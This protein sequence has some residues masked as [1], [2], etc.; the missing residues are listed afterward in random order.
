MPER[1]VYCGGL[2]APKKPGA[3]H[4]DVN[5][6][7]GSPQRVNLQVGDLSR[8]L[9]ENIPLVLTDMLEIAAYV[10]CA[11]QFTKR[12]TSQMTGMGAEWRRRFRFKI[13]VRRPAIW[14]DPQVGE[15]LNE[16]LTFLSE[17]EYEFAFEQGTELQ[18]LQ[19]YFPF[20][21]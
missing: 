21:D 17:D 4:I 6:P 19:A 5:A 20:N 15:A 16:T 14:T 8:R 3:L 1:Y 11:D 7:I 10:Y 18:P 12:G 2:A 13:P 9:A